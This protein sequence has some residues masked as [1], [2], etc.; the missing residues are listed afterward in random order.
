[1][2]TFTSNVAYQGGDLYIKDTLNLIVFDSHYHS[3][4]KSFNDGGSIYYH[5][6]R[7]PS[8]VTIQFAMLSGTYSTY[9]QISSANNGGLLNF[10]I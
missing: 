1:M 9:E 7:Y 10:N 4:S 8:P 6:S 5:D 3:Y 2:N